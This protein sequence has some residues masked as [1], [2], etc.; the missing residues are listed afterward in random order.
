VTYTNTLLIAMDNSQ[1]GYY[2][3]NTNQLTQ[4]VY[5]GTG[6]VALDSLGICSKFICTLNN[7][8]RILICYIIVSYLSVTREYRANFRN[9]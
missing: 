8:R 9:K 3:M 5:L 7:F 2:D 4:V 6:F 1:L